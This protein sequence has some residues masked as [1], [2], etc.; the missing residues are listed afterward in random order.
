M[1]VSPG[2]VYSNRDSSETIT[3]N[4]PKFGVN[5]QKDHVNNGALIKGSVALVIN[6]KTGYIA[7]QFHI[8]FDDDFTT[9][10]TMITN[11]LP[12][13]RENIFNNHRELPQEEFQFIIEKQW[14]TLTDHSKGYR[15]LNNNSPSDQ[16]EGAN[17]C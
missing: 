12:D 10:S 15:K 17:S 2:F 8:V 13:N 7:L 5:I 3:S 11:K 6:I 16:I 1:P 4:E 9:T 14:K